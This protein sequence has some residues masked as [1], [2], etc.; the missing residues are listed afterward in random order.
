MEKAGE[1]G[2]LNLWGEERGD[3]AET[4]L[5][6][7]LWTKPVVTGTRGFEPFKGF[8]ILA[9][10]TWH[11][12][13]L[14]CG[15]SRRW[16]WETRLFVCVFTYEGAEGSGQCLGSR[17]FDNAQCRGQASVVVLRGI[18]NVLVHVQVPWLHLL[19]ALVYTPDGFRRPL[20]RVEMVLHSG[21]LR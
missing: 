17:I 19:V 9:G 14:V 18:Y 2:N 3:E 16:F 21:A 4:Y 11:I 10:L 8:P 7:G 6:S 12:M 15:E 20:V 5:L 1:Q 13:V